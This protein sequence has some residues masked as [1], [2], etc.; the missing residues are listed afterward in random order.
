MKEH[1]VAFMAFARGSESK[2]IVRKLY[3]GIGVGALSHGGTLR[4][5]R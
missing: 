2:E 4:V 3:I 5:L 1:N